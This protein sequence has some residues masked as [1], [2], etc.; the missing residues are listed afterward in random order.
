MIW[1]K[2]IIFFEELQVD[3]DWFNG[4]GAWNLCYNWGEF[5]I[6]LGFNSPRSYLIL[7]FFHVDFVLGG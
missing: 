1:L 5:F 4:V 2:N 7:Y 6:E 3:D